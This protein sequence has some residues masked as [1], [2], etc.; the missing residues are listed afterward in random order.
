[1]Y[2]TSVV[3]ATTTTYGSNYPS[4]MLSGQQQQS[5][6]D[7]YTAVILEESEKLY[8]TL[9]TELTN[10]FITTAA[11]AAIRASSL[12]SLGNNTNNHKLT[13]KSDNT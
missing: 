9:N 4:L 7:S 3:T 11:A 10:R 2:N 5:F 6:I 8:N 13:H 12:P 1:M